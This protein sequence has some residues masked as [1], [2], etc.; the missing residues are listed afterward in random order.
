MVTATFLVFHEPTLLITQMGST[1]ARVNLK[2]MSVC[3]AEP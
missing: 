2:Q 1:L 3:R